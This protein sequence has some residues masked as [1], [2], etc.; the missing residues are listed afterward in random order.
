MEFFHPALAP[1]TIAFMILGLIALLEVGGLLFGVAFSG[2]IDAALPDFEIDADI[3]ADIEGELET[4]G[5]MI[6]GL[7]SWLGL[8]KVPFLIVLAA[9]LGSFGAIGLLLQNAINGAF[10]FFPPALVA[11]PVALFAAL[12]VTRILSVGVAK[13]FPKEETDAVSAETLIGRIATIIRG[14]ASTGSPAEAKLTDATGHTHY[15]LV[16]PDTQKSQFVAG[17]QVLLTERNGAVFRGAIN[18]NEA[19]TT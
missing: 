2:L 19:L 13:I 3:D 7:L 16:E 1:F 9:F 11:T 18:E 10:G 17:D 5:G 6:G 4:G 14:V 12:P 15:V 8:G